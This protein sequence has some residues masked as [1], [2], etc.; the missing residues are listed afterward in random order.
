MIRALMVWVL[1]CDIAVANPDTGTDEAA[2]GWFVNGQLLYQEGRY[3]N[4]LVAFEAAYRMSARPTILRSIAYCHEQLGELEQAVDVLY[5][6][7]GLSSADKWAEI[8]R[9]ISRLEFQLEQQ[10]NEAGLQQPSPAAAPAPA[11]APVK[12]PVIPP[13]RTRYEPPKWRVGAGPLVLYSVAGVGAIVGGVFA[14]NASRAREQTATL[15]SQGDA[16]FCRAEAAPY[17][18]QDWL[19]SLIADTGFSVAGAGLVGGTVWMVVDNSN[20]RSVQVGVGP[21]GMGLRGKF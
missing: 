17:I 16:I 9:R 4:A 13:Q 15:C 19:Y 8:D 14:F 7:R 2:R 21:A 10:Q 11:P 6:F 12:E 1:C 3:R 18:N 5:R 20:A